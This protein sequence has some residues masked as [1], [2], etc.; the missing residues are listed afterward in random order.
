MKPLEYSPAL[1]FFH[2][3][4]KACEL[5][6]LVFAFLMITCLVFSSLSE[7]GNL[8]TLKSVPIPSNNPQT[9]EKIELGKKLFF[10]R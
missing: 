3:V 2:A 5:S 8:E 1:R 4:P 6:V 9:P 10:D 7:A